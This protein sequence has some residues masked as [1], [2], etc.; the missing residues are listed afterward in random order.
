MVS[1]DENMLPYGSASLSSTS[2]V[3]Q[4]RASDRLLEFHGSSI[5]VYVCSHIVFR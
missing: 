1:M 3:P 5:V 4:A 2:V